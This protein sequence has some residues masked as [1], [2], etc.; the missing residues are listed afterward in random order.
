MPKIDVSAFYG[1][2]P[3]VPAR[4]LPNE[5]AVKALDCQLEVGNLEPYKGLLDTAE[6]LDIQHKTIFKFKDWWFKW[7]TVVDVEISPV[8]GDPWDRVYFTSPTGVRVT[9]NQIFNGAGDLPAASYP[10]GVPAPENAIT[11]VEL[12]PNPLPAADDASDDETRFYVYTLVSEQGEEGP[13]SPISNQVDVKYPASTVQLTF[14]DENSLSGNIKTRRIYRSS[15]EGGIADFY[16]I[17]D[18]PTNQNAFVD[19]VGPDDEGGPLETETFEGPNDKMNHLKLMPNGIMAGGYDRT[20]CFSEPYELHAWPVGYQL[21]TDHEIMAMECV[22]NMLLVGTKGNPW[23]FQG[24]TSD[25]M[26]GRK[27]RSKQACVSR[28]S[29][30]NIDSMI[31]YASQ[32]GLC[33]FTGSDVVL[34]TDEIIT[35]EQWQALEPE[36][37][38]AYYYDG[39]YVA[40]YGP[41]LDKSFIFDPK[42]GALTFHSIGSNLGFTDLKDGTLY[43]RGNDQRKLAKWNQGQPMQ[44]TWRSKEYYAFYP[45]FSTL[46]VRAVEPDKVGL[47]VMQ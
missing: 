20:V 35:L 25:A 32:N 11:A 7:T 14:S 26:S 45:T 6:L 3:K 15:T 13:Q 42:L 34:L 36:T 9:N 37:I 29:M 23:V 19:N 38:E 28:R 41:N 16:K 2:R 22:D 31:I 1:E 12:P 17:A 4:G 24:V 44:Y 40:C 8:I 27:L 18:I 46:Y 5:N 43:V 21:T 10:L 47:R 39:K 33:A 30:R